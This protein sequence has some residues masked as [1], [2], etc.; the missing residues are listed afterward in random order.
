MGQLS[1]S[2]LA[3]LDGCITDA[4]GSLDW[5][6]P[7]DGRIWRSAD[8]IVYSSMLNDVA[9]PRTCY[10]TDFGSHSPSPTSSSSTAAWFTCTSGSS[11]E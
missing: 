2:G 11:Y 6:R 8:K 3:S 5:A 7:D 9:T 1:Y 10:P 4:N